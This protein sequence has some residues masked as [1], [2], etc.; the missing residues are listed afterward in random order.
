MVEHQQHLTDP[1]VHDRSDDPLRAALLDIG[2]DH[3]GCHLLVTRLEDT[4]DGPGWW[5]LDCE[6]HETGPLI[7]FADLAAALSGEPTE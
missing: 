3:E 1:S 7:D 2:S 6:D 5:V 4:D